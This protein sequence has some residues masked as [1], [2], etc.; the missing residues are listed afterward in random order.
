FED[1]ETGARIQTQ[2]WLIRKEYKKRVSEFI[3]GLEYQLREAM[4]DYVVVNTATPFELSL[5]SYL[6]KREKLF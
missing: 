2:P 3:K 6:Y 5:L 4:I 1:L